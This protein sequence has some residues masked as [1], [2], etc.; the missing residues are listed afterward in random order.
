MGV[1]D[2]YED[3]NDAWNPEIE[4][5][6]EVS[7]VNSISNKYLYNKCFIDTGIMGAAFGVI[8]ALILS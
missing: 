4:I 8:I 2:T 3:S 6:C 7:N 1:K 5:T